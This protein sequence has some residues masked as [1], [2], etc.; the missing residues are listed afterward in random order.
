MIHLIQVPVVTLARVTAA[1]RL[2]INQAVAPH[3]QNLVR[4]VAAIHHRRDQ[5]RDP[6]S[7]LRLRDLV[8][9][10]VVAHLRKGLL[11]TVMSPSILRSHLR[12]QVLPRILFRKRRQ[13]IVCLQ[14]E[15]RFVRWR[16]RILSN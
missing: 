3:P 15:S 11:V 4:E 2:V 10:T 8:A 16:T 7:A 1:I 14:C 12:I 5:V 6:V 13:E 9:R